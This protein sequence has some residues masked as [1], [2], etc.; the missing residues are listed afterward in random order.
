M[1]LYLRIQDQKTNITVFPIHKQNRVKYARTVMY[2]CD[3]VC[4]YH[5]INKFKFWS[6]ITR[7]SPHINNSN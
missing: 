7:N 2:P 3:A 1:I 6:P 4:V 5:L